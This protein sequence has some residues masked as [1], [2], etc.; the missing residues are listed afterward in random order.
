MFKDILNN[1]ILK[2]GC[3]AK[4]LAKESGLSEAAVSRYR[5]GE[6]IPKPETE[7]FLKLCRGIGR[8]AEKNGIN[9]ITE[10]NAAAELSGYARAGN[11]KAES[12]RLNLNLLISTL[13]VNVSEV[14]RELKYDSSYLS[15]IRNG[16]R[17]PSNVKALA[18]GFGR[19]IAR[20]FADGEKALQ[21]NELLGLPQDREFSATEYASAVTA[22]LLSAEEY[23]QE[24]IGVMNFLRKLDDF[25]LNNYIRTI[26]FDELKI[27]HIPFYKPQTKNY[28]GLESMKKA[29]LDFLKAAVLSKSAGS[30]FMFSD[31]QMDDMAADVEFQKKYMYGVALMLKKGLYLNVVHNLNRPFNE[32]IIGLE[33]WIPLYMTGQISPYYLNGVHNKLFCRLINV[34]D[35]AALTGESLTGHH[36]EGR[37]R[38]AANKEELDYLKKYSG[39]ILKKALPLMRIYRADASA[40]LNTFLHNDSE[41]GGA[42]AGVLAAPPI[43]TMSDKLLNKILDLNSVDDVGKGAILDFAVKERIR[44]ERLLKNCSVQIEIPKYTKEEF[45]KNKP[46]LALANMF[47]E[48]SVPYSYDDYM[49]HLKQ[50]GEYAEKRQNFIIKSGSADLFL[51]F[52]NIQVIINKGK[53]VLISKNNAP[54]IHFL[55]QH[56][57][58]RKAIEDLTDLKLP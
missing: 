6:R 35:F 32:L 24:N 43:Y 44:A 5:S 13:S 10:Q 40:E 31:M 58:L 56:P 27:P 14:S 26:H 57:I 36:A 41:Y 39:Y 8:I 16:H 28:Y 1:Y 53:W 11:F 37:Y 19:F 29:E 12:F 54:A 20:K 45:E 50:T 2:L 22:W 49:M 23:R 18:E 3:S 34:S 48:D 21:I 51:P 33:G 42:R 38:L 55:I 9:G 7:D 25:D 46:S 17:Q 15:R 47:Y 52:R 4:E 30:V